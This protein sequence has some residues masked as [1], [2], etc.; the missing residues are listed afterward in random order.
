VGKQQKDANRL[1]LFP[2]SPDK[3]IPKEGRKVV[4]SNKSYELREPTVPYGGNFTHK[5][6]HLRHQNT[7]FWN[8]I[9]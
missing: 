3:F 5:N 8:D 9:I 2:L 6:G 4:G 1:Q 7:Y